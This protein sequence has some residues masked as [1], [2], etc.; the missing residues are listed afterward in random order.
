MPESEQIAGSDVSNIGPRS[1]GRG[2][3]RKRPPRG[4]GP[5]NT[6][7]PHLPLAALSVSLDGFHTHSSSN[8]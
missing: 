3:G 8:P 2:R 7:N 5:G 4:R 1:N 6:T